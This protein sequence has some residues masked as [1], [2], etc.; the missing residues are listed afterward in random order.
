M[1]TEEHEVIIGFGGNVPC[2]DGIACVVD[3]CTVGTNG[4]RSIGII[5]T[6]RFYLW[7]LRIH[8]VA[9]V[10]LYSWLAL[11]HFVIFVEVG[12]IRVWAQHLAAAYCNGE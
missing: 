10:A 1:C 8:Q 3:L 5:S 6:P 4:L 9:G 12:Y 11:H 7:Q 2:F